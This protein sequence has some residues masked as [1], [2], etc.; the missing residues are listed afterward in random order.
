MNL[1]DDE[2]VA[3]LSQALEGEVD[4]SARRRAEYSTDASTYRMLPRVV[5]QPK[6]SADVR[7]ALEIARQAGVPI[8]SRGAGTS[9]AGN[10]VGAGIILDFSRHMDKI[11]EIDPE[12]RTAR[13]Q[14]GVIESD[15]QKAAAPFGLRFGPDPS[16]QNRATFG[17]MIGNNACGPHAVA[18]GRTA[19]NIHELQ[20]LLA[21]GTQITAGQGELQI[22]GLKQVINE[23]LALIRTEMGRFKRQVSGYSLEHLLPENGTDLA[24]FLVGSEGTLGIVTEAT[25]RLVPAADS[26]ALV[27]LSYP[28]MPAAAD[29]VV[30]LLE[31]H[32]LAVEGMDAKL[33][34]VVRKHKGSV[35]ELPAGAGWLFIEIGARTGRIRHPS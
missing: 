10:A 22:S 19:D 5:V 14:P 18:Y 21:D 20:V 27:I 29:D 33:V 32:P 34:E 6:N 31:F 9:C 7:A 13:V 3:R 1:T 26:P 11:L 30:P 28:D 16:T 23:H 35:P 25:L 17:G 15:L 8:T 4:G 2:L 12:N 24:K